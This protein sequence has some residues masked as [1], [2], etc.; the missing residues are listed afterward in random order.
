MAMTNPTEEP[1]EMTKE[2]ATTKL[3]LLPLLVPVTVEYGENDD[4]V[5]MLDFSYPTIPGPGDNVIQVSLA[6]TEQQLKDL[7]AN[8]PIAPVDRL[9]SLAIMLSPPQVPG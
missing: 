8:L 2:Q 4:G 1:Q 9:A 5:P 7:V 6:P 3:S